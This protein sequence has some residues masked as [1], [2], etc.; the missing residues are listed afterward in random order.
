MNLRHSATLS[1]GTKFPSTKLNPIL[2]PPN[3]S[4]YWQRQIIFS[5][6]A[7]INV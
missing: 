2:T 3:L 6:Y 7:I 5:I 4:L 1:V